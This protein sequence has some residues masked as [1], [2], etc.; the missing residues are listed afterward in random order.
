MGSPSGIGAPWGCGNAA[1]TK[2]PGI[3][4]IWE[5]CRRQRAGIPSSPW[6]H[7]AQLGAL[8][9]GKPA[10]FCSLWNFPACNNSKK[11]P[12]SIIW[13]RVLSAVT[14]CS[15]QYAVKFLISQQGCS[16]RL[17]LKNTQGCCS[18]HGETREGPAWI[19]GWGGKL[20]FEGC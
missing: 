11:K 4:G 10:W 12:N 17:C 18:E 20:G 9:G 8:G 1:R 2:T 19:R 3:L 16:G 5:S 14:I 6:V 15:A 13:G 7:P